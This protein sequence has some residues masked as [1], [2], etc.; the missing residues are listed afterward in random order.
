MGLVIATDM[1]SNGG[2][3]APATARKQPVRTMESGPVSGVIAASQLSRRLVRALSLWLCCSSWESGT[4]CSRPC[5]SRRG[6]R[7]RAA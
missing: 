1:Q 3:M 5:P 7:G 6:K 2:V 4:T